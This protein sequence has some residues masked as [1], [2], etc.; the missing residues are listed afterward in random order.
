LAIDDI[1]KTIG[2][3]E[4]TSCY[5][6]KPLEKIDSSKVDDYVFHKIVVRKGEIITPKAIETKIFLYYTG[7]VI[8]RQY[9]IWRASADY[10]LSTI[11][12]R[13]VKLGSLPSVTN[14]IVT[15]P[16]QTG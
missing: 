6:I 14:D 11:S 8:G 9:I 4:K 10:F 13:Y 15:K 2:H 12:G 3:K 5:E 16:I 1:E 7:A